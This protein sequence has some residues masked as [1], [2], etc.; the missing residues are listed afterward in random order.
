[1]HYIIRFIH[2]LTKPFLLISVP[3]SQISTDRYMTNLSDDVL[4]YQ[5]KFIKIISEL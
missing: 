5:I 3:N 1:M 2:C 4:Q